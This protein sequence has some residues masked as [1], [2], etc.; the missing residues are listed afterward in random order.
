MEIFENIFWSVISGLVASGVFLIVISICR[1]RIEISPLIARE[2][3]AGGK[4]FVFKFIN[5]SRRSCINIRVEAT[6][7][8]LTQ[9]QGGTTVWTTHLP[10][11]KSEV[12]EVAKFNKKDPNGD[13]AWRFVTEEDLDAVW[14]SDNDFVRFRVLATD[15]LTSFSKSFS[16]EF[17]VPRNSI[18]SGSHHF[19][20]DLDVS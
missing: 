3:D 4:F 10:L 17:R 11:K 6:L 16:K 2:Q 18:K 15:S 12:F 14:V 1:P 5:K 8:K 20:E 7:A 13:Y 9:V 19:G